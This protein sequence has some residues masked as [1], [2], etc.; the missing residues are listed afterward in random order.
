MRT[1]SE[2]E[3]LY[4]RAKKLLVENREFLDAVANALIEKEVLTNSDIKKI[5]ENLRVA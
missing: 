5:K 2:M 3:R 1:F 4:N